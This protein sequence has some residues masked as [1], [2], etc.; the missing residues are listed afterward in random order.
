MAANSALIYDSSSTLTLCPQICN[1][2]MQ[3][4]TYKSKAKYIKIENK[5]EKYIYAFFIAVVCQ[6][7]IQL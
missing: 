5:I 2:D 6:F 4:N 7:I 1:T 3:H